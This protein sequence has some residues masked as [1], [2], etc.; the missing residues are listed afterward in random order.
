[1]GAFSPV[2]TGRT[3]R[4]LLIA[5]IASIAFAF[6]GFAAA[7]AHANPFPFLGSFTGPSLDS[8]WVMPGNETVGGTGGLAEN[9]SAVL[10]GTN[11]TPGWLQLTAATGNEV[12]WVYNTTPFPSNSGVLVNFDYA[13]YG[14]RGADGLTFFLFGSNTGDPNGTTPLPLTTGPTG[15]SLGYA[16][17][18]SMHMD[19][20][21]NAYVGVG[22]DE[23]GNFGRDSHFCG[24]TG[25]LGNGPG[26]YPNY[27]VVRGPGNAQ[28]GYA[29]QTGAPVVDP[30]NVAEQL[31]GTSIADDR[32]VTVL[33]TPS[34]LLSVYI[35]FP[36]G[37][38][39]T[40][41]S[42]YQ[43]T[44]TP[45][46]YLQLGFV[47]STGG[48]TDYHNIRENA[49]TEPVD[50][51]T[52]VSS[53]TA[54]AARGA[55][56]TDTFT[57]NNAGPNESAATQIT[58]NTPST[59]LSNVSWTC[60]GTCNATS[61]SGLPSDTIDLPVGDTATYTITGTDN[62]TSDAQAQIQLTAT[63]SGAT[64][65]SLPGDNV[66]TATTLL[67]P[68]A[69]TAPAFT[70]ADGGTNYTGVATETQGTYFGNG[71]N[72]T[73]QWQRCAPDG[74]NCTDISGQTATTYDTTAADR[75]STVRVAETASNAAGS[76][77]TVYTPV[78]P[79]LP[80]T[81]LST[82]TAANTNQ[83]SASFTLG[84]SNYAAGQVS[85]ECNLDGAG[86]SNCSS[87]PTF[88][89]LADGP[90]TLQARSVYAGLSDPSPQSFSWIVD[91]VAPPAPV[92]TVPA[93]ASFTNNN[94]PPIIGTAEANNT[95]TV[96]IDGSSVGTAPVN[97]SGNWTYTPTVALTDGAH[98][99]KATATDPASNMSGFSNTNNF[100][101]DT[102][103]P[104]APVVTVPADASFT[105]NNKPPIS[106]TAEANNTVTVYIDGSSV[107]TAPVN[108][109]G[110]WTYTPTVALTDGAHAVKATATDP[111]SNVSGFSNT[112]NFTV[113]TVAPP[114]PVVSVPANASFTNNNKPPIAGTA[115]ANNTV[116]VYIDGS[117]VGT[118]PVNGSGNWTYTPTVALTD[119]AHA[120]KATATDP[121]SN[122]SGFS[123]T[124]NFT[125]DTVAPPAPVV[126]VPA[127]ASFTNNNKP[128]ISGTAEANNTVTVYIDGSSVGTAPVNG[129]GN[130]TYTPTVAL[131]DG[132]HA[133]KAT[134]TD[135]ASNVSGFSNTNNFT[136]DTVAPP[137]PVVRVPADASFTNNNKPPISGTAE[138][139]N[140][141]TVYIDGSSVG[142]TP[143]NGSGNW[144]YTP[145]VA[146]T[147]GAHAVKAT[148]TDPA[149]NVSGFSNTNNFTVDTVAPPAPAVTVPADASFTNNN[150][151][152]ISGTAEANNT[153]TVYIDGSSVGTTPVNGSGNWTYTPTVALTDGAHAVKA[154]ATDPASNVSGFSNTNNFTVDTVAP[155]APVV[156]VPADASFTN[157]NKPPISGTAEA[158]NT[159]TVYIDGSSVGTAPV[160]GSG[161]WTYTPTVALTDGAHAVKA[162]ATDPASNVSGFSNTNNF[163]VDTVAPAAPV[164]SVPA[165]AS[166]TNNNK[167]PISGTAEA[168]STV[169]VYIDG[170]SVGT[171][172]VNGSG[173]WTYTPTVALTT[174]ST[175]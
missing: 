139:N 154:T 85:Y 20:L 21:T 103:A 5:L 87:T 109:S 152:P 69:L 99:V 165:N 93:N 155:P 110:N 14:G 59:T 156:T 174:A 116:T 54:N 112:N 84:T 65:Q 102:V 175:R 56:I 126:S 91:T 170:S 143:V 161:N 113:D 108:G 17:C 96:Y 1:M 44:S 43:L 53:S 29:Y 133:V 129:S 60:T 124:N 92:V 101:V 166:F 51:Q 23:Y 39:Q 34:G 75:G 135:P 151:P 35:T 9:N 130:W 41:T 134:A 3:S 128:P 68:V 80:I 137:A 140:T 70:L 31:K 111:A 2:L 28:S 123:N 52:R 158:N 114:A 173:N 121:A 79:L 147:D 141:V 66:A 153:V 105:N 55:T 38:T 148:A 26:G 67:P 169:T 127:N 157:N 136:V 106:G 13:D 159:V 94:K 104:P 149:S 171:A 10:T 122:V 145:T 150:K 27:L 119:G 172:P 33:I 86:W 90:H 125:V 61:G 16:D 98:A 81:T 58:A 22:L 49:V 24:V 46:A 131:T 40:V 74:S 83:T 8:G 78:F 7:P 42:G 32:H 48:S 163:T 12:G 77:S 76:T 118:A 164:V 63:P 142:T 167:P 37:N 71:V 6:A 62:S 95:V 50:V 138:A 132:A 73:E 57:V 120:V 88:S 72:V 144:T 168:N 117:S 64:G 97:G 160:N 15:G 18:P 115:E 45:P 47:A 25:G 36:D 89:G 82:S 4:A 162:T 146:L 107:G 30:G 19:G 100:T 11:S